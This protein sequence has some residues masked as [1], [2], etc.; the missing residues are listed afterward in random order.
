ML[1][2]R[3]EPAV[4]VSRIFLGVRL[5]CARCHDHPFDR[6]TQRDFEQV[7]R[8]FQAFEIRELNDQNFELLDRV[9]ANRRVPPD[10]LPRFFTSAVPRTA[11]W[12]DEFALFV[13]SCKPFA[14]TYANRIWY[15]L[16]GRG[17]V[18]PPMT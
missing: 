15:Q 8:F 9:E 10:E 17:I 13:T 16:M 6:W 7:S 2:H 4:R 5:D 3:E 14:R 1:R 18:D 12:R 11:A